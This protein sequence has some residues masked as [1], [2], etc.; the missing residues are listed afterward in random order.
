VHVSDE[1]GRTAISSL[2]KP[3]PLRY[4]DK[5]P[6]L[7][8]EGFRLTVNSR[9]ERGH[10]PHVHVIKAGT[11]VLI[12][13]DSSLTPYKLVGMSKRDVTRARELVAEH[14]GQL[15]EWWMKFNG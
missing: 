13:L 7:E 4:R 1:S 8:I 12:T 6:T 11:K 10:K 2:T 15:L 14:F 3:I 5:V 9:D